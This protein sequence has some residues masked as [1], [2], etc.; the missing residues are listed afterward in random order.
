MIKKKTLPVILKSSSRSPMFWC[1]WGAGCCPM[2]CLATA[3]ATG[4]PS[5][6]SAGN[7]IFCL[8][9]FGFLIE[10]IFSP[11][12]SPSRF[13]SW[14]GS[15]CCQEQEACRQGQSHPGAAATLKPP[16]LGA[17]WRAPAGKSETRHWP[18]VAWHR[19]FAFLACMFPALTFKTQAWS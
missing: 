7:K 13:A 14:H 1:R 12:S 11:V 4:T 8:F 17:C 18:Y 19:Y 3:L 9:V 15:W 16:W 2:G 6:L 10:L 5:F